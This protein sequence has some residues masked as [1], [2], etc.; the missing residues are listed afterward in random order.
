MSAFLEE[1]A[2]FSVFHSFFSLSFPWSPAWLQASR[3]RHLPP[4][5]ARRGALFIIILF[6]FLIFSGAVLLLS[7]Q[8]RKGTKKKK[9]KSETVGL[10]IK[11][12]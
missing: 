12:K 10:R 5:P 8:L 6:Q 2:H 11:N 4:D 1:T 7:F 3:G 9:K